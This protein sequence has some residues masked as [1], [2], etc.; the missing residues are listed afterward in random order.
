MI[1]AGSY[2]SK[3]YFYNAQTI[4]RNIKIN[5]HQMSKKYNG[6]FTELEVHNGPE[7]ARAYL[8]NELNFKAYAPGFE[9]THG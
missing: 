1:L 5:Y 6:W 9:A 4:T 2:N 8:D 3:V 7:V